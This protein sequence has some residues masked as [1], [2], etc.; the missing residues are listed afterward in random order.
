MPKRTYK[1][2][3]G[4]HNITR[5]ICD[6]AKAEGVNPF[7]D[8]EM[9]KWVAARRKK[10]DSKANSQTV[11]TAE[12]SEGK[13]LTLEQLE[14]EL[15]SAP[16]PQI[17]QMRKIQI[18]GLREGL[19]FRQ[20]RSELIS[21]HEVA[22][23]DIRIANADRAAFIK[24]ENDLPPKGVGL[25]EADMQ[26]AFRPVLRNNMEMTADALSEFWK[27]TPEMQMIIRFSLGLMDGKK[28]KFDPFTGAEL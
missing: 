14:V 12:D 21:R 6:Y 28:W 10:N 22:E 20:E 19:K 5:A 18:S 1:E 17:A 11:P 26:K 4:I 27:D 24:L 9:S 15:S 13:P 2:I 8:A 25:D 3:C 16:T 7:N 23:R